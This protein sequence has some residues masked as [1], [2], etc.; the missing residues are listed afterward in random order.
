M[1]YKDEVLAMRTCLKILTLLAFYS[2]ITEARSY[3]PPDTIDKRILLKSNGSDRPVHQAKTDKWYASKFSIP[4]NF[5]P[6]IAINR[7]YIS[8]IQVALHDFFSSDESFSRRDR[9]ELLGIIKNDLNN[10][11]LISITEKNLI[12]DKIR[13]IKSTPAFNLWKS[14]RTKLIVLVD[15]KKSNLIIHGHVKIFDAITQKLLEEF[16]LEA[17]E[18]QF[19][20]FAHSIS[21]KIYECSTGEGPYLNSKIAFIDESRKIVKSVKIM[22]ID[23]HNVKS[24]FDKS[25]ICLSPRF[26]PNGRYMTY[27]SYPVKFSKI[28]RRNVLAPGKVFIVDLKNRTMRSIII[29][30]MQYAPRFSND[31][32]KIIFSRTIKGA[33]CICTYDLE[34][35]KI[36]Q[37]TKPFLRSID[38]SP[39][40][41]KNND[42]IVFNSDRTG[43]QQI[44]T[45]NSDG[46]NMT[47]I[48]SGE[49]R[50]ATPVWSPRNDYIAFT[51]MLNGTFYI[52]IMKPDGTRER[53]LA[54]GYMVESPCWSKNG[55][56]I[57]YTAK[58]HAKDSSKIYAVDI[59]GMGEQS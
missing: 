36:E 26:S 31:S 12:F 50:Y 11:N 2:T 51:K 17:S 57:F 32:R 20:S 18:G 10:T 58:H 8:K 21:D 52:G 15:V 24:I 41:S 13:D 14:S 6:T 43:S 9:E 56:V 40:F 5:T 35:K 55:R 16:T 39:C 29:K 19:R 28:R 37:I 47:R 22:D 25:T 59:T 33:S 27:F 48:S 46:S 1:Y 7:G 4:Q 38:T 30:G 45:M 54:E 34:T 23:G 53:M 44:Y 49:G 3:S 42:K